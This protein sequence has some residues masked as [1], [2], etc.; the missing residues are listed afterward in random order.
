MTDKP[1]F[2]GHHVV[3]QKTFKA[4]DLVKKLSQEEL[5]D[6]HGLRNL[7]VLPADQTL[8]ARMG[9]SPHTGGPLSAYTDEL[10]AT[11][12]DLEY[13]PTARPPCAATRPPPSASPPAST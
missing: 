2:Q 4:S 3:E 6:L 13:P 11:L 1:V 7:V 10:A 8:A 12:R 5:F 9:L